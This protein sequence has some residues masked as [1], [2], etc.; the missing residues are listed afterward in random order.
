MASSF[1]RGLG[2]D[3]PTIV[4]PELGSEETYSKFIK[5]LDFIYHSAGGPNPL[6]VRDAS[7]MMQQ[8][9]EDFVSSRKGPIKELPWL[10][11]RLNPPNLDIPPSLDVPLPP[12]FDGVR[13][14]WEK[15]AD[16]AFVP[17][18]PPL[19]YLQNPPEKTYEPKTELDKF[20]V[21][22]LAEH[23][24]NELH[25]LARSD[26]KYAD[27]LIT[28]GSP[29]HTMGWEQISR[30][31]ATWAIDNTREGVDLLRSIQHQKS[32]TEMFHTGEIL[33]RR[34]LVDYSA[35]SSHSVMLPMPADLSLA[36]RQ[37]NQEL[38]RL[39]E[40]IRN[41][42]DNPA[43][44]IP[45]YDVRS[46][47]LLLGFR[48]IIDGCRWHLEHE[49]TNDEKTLVM[50]DET[51]EQAYLG[52][53]TV[54]QTCNTPGDD[55]HR[56]RAH[57][58]IS[59]LIAG[60]KVDNPDG[61][62]RG[63]DRPL[64]YETADYLDAFMAVGQYAEVGQETASLLMNR[65]RI[66]WTAHEGIRPIFGDFRTSHDTLRQ[67]LS[68]MA[69]IYLRM[70]EWQKR[71]YEGLIRKK[72]AEVD[73]KIQQNERA[74]KS[75]EEPLLYVPS[76]E[77]PQ[78]LHPD[79]Y[80]LRFST[81]ADLYKSQSL[82][83][84]YTWG[85]LYGDKNSRRY[86]G[87]VQAQST[88][89]EGKTKVETSGFL[90]FGAGGAY[91][92]E[93]GLIHPGGEV[94]PNIQALNLDFARETSSELEQIKINPEQTWIE[95][96]NELPSV[97]VE[98]R[99]GVEGAKIVEDL[100]E[101]NPETGSVK[102]ISNFAAALERLLGRKPSEEETDFISLLE[103]LSMLNETQMGIDSAS[104]EN[105]TEILERMRS[106][107]ASQGDIDQGSLL[108]MM[109]ATTGAIPRELLVEL[110][111]K[112]YKS[113]ESALTLEL[114]TTLEGLDNRRLSVLFHLKEKSHP[115][116]DS[117]KSMR[118]Y[119]NSKVG[120]PN[121]DS[122]SD[123]EFQRLATNVISKVTKLL[124]NNK[125]YD[126]TM[127]SPLVAVLAAKEKGHLA[128][129]CAVDGQALL[130]LLKFISPELSS[131]C[132]QTY[133]PEELLPLQDWYQ[134]IESA[135]DSGAS[136][137]A[138]TQT[139]FTNDQGLNQVVVADAT[140]GSTFSITPDKIHDRPDKNAIMQYGQAMHTFS[141]H[142]Y[143]GERESLGMCV[144]GGSY[145]MSSLAMDVGE[146]D[147]ARLANPDDPELHR[148]ILIDEDRS[149]EDRAKS[150]DYLL[151]IQPRWLTM[152]PVYDFHRALTADS[153]RLV[154]QLGR[155]SDRWGGSLFSANIL[156]KAKYFS[157]EINREGESL[158]GLLTKE[159][160]TMSDDR[161]EN[162]LTKNNAFLVSDDVV[163]IKN[164]R[165]DYL[166]KIE[167][168]KLMD[169]DESEKDIESIVKNE[170]LAEVAHDH[171]VSSENLMRA[172]GTLYAEENREKQLK[173]NESPS[174]GSVVTQEFNQQMNKRS[175]QI[176]RDTVNEKPN[177][178]NILD[179]SLFEKTKP[180][181]Q[182]L[183]L[184]KYLSDENGQ[185]VS[186][187]MRDKRIRALQ[188]VITQVSLGL[189]MKKTQKA[190]G[191]SGR[192]SKTEIVLREIEDQVVEMANEL[193]AGL[194]E[195]AKRLKIEI[196]RYSPQTLLV[197]NDNELLALN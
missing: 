117:R 81:A 94:K 6:S 139:N 25:R 9:V 120:E 127:K 50:L 55:H 171:E 187:E 112:N 106:G 121:Y 66:K 114:A 65:S 147:Y 124:H 3:I 15:K 37:A 175:S 159:I 62:G 51:I 71:T 142:I 178:S 45:D 183:A 156:K 4:I 170:T 102:A 158:Y 10:E 75:L 29:L 153:L 96:L 186:E 146:L 189:T 1:D 184:T 126:A 131:Y 87:K 176:V 99:L 149:I 69:V 169:S 54:L 133:G 181:I 11:E 150:L 107:E 190:L 174:F 97:L 118:E 188:Q 5:N 48:N 167:A 27:A 36:Y 85:N 61:E 165:K 180:E 196:P 83:S 77:I 123:P 193:H 67:Q 155:E 108:I 70:P 59:T 41:K 52:F 56:F 14:I 19:E 49:T 64:P 132:A 110:V 168:R 191:A 148:Q 141:P 122:Q 130:A 76:R 32:V 109:M 101:T 134:H 16:V 160:A 113:L 82:N 152:T 38:N 137:H 129:R 90:G 22:L 157:E 104:P 18:A 161:I 145:V 2:H 195:S 17:Y 72:F 28:G 74:G 144:R 197:N 30:V 103:E 105:I 143:N 20:A 58:D 138:F 151:M 140:S 79:M 60:V 128:A 88:W 136:S 8:T 80:P 111:L 125:T 164:A 163:A 78:V 42:I 24:L 21:F 116:L 135:R 194:A 173:E 84:F 192:S 154:V 93:Y 182:D 7:L 86:D 39:H 23:G 47:D 57:H 12:D 98:S 95:K 43:K 115:I 40:D 53:N 44:Q 185:R 68:T 63:G 162:I 26:P 179:V 89:D 33:P 35:E 92:D 177:K 166:A 91:V 31:H 119:L 73:T 46:D 34:K 13:T 100:L 172:V